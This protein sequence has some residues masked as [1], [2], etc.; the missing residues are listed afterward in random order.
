MATALPFSAQ[1]T[2]GLARTVLIG[3]RPVA[4]TGSGGLCTP[5]HPGIVDAFA[6]PPTQQGTVVAGSATVLVEDRPL[7]GTGSACRTCTGTG[8]LTATA[9]DVQVGG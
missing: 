4:T 2:T 7:A 5:P 9:A 6:A 3:G 1:L 8:S